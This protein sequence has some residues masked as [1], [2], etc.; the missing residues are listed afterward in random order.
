VI[1]DFGG[2]G[3]YFVPSLVLAAI[4]GIE[5]CN[6]DKPMERLLSRLA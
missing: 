3:A 2:I 6:G 1:R 4:A 5:C